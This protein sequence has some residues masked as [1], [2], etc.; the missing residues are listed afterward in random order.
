MMKLLLVVV[1][2]VEVLVI[3]GEM[4]CVMMNWKHNLEIHASFININPL[5]SIQQTLRHTDSLT[6]WIELIELLVLCSS[7]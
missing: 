4:E 5:I 3:V 6:S 7:P 2:V 1:K